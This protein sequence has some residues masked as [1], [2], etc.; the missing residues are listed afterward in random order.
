[1]GTLLFLFI[2]PICYLL[3]RLTRSSRLPPG[4]RGYPV[5]G[6][7]LDIPATQQWKTFSEWTKIYGDVMCLKLPMHH[8]IVLGSPQA[9]SD[10]M[11]KRSD[12]YSDRPISIMDELIGWDW[13]FAAMRYSLKWRAYRK[14]FH[15]HFNQN[16]VHTF[17]PI[18]LRE[19]RAFLGRMLGS[20]ESE[21]LGQHIRQINTAIILKIAYDMDITDVNDEY[22]RLAQEATLGFSMAHGLGATWVDLFPVL[23]HLPNWMPGMK[24][25]KMAD[26]YRSISWKM[27]HAPFGKVKQDINEE[28]ATSSLAHKL[29]ERHQG[30]TKDGFDGEELARNVAAIAYAGAAH[31][32]NKS[33]HS[34]IQYP[35]CRRN[36]ICIG[37]GRPLKPNWDESSDKISSIAIAS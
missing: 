35:S 6:N 29:L 1:M 21:S 8:V 26:Y 24:F 31:T 36:L 19:C 15:Q 13:A 30:T 18:Q 20:S 11:E 7:I 37:M 4:Q 33:S 12:I 23:R 25:K 5:I 34:F 27:V 22:V 16:E 28:K 3:L 32:V 10:L 17:Q 2:V 9:V 14:A